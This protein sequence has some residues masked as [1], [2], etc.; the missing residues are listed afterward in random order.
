MSQLS[1]RGSNISGLPQIHEE[2]DGENGEDDEDVD[3]LSS[4]SN[5]SDIS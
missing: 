3:S 1:R 5:R 4:L 2:P